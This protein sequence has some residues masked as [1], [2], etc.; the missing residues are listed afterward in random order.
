M[1]RKLIAS[2]LLGP[3]LMASAAGCADRK[4]EVELPKQE[5]PLPKDG[6]QA[7]GVATKGGKP[8]NPAAPAK[9]EQ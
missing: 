1:L 7:A 2:G 5:F 6:P 8:P 3:V 4:K 9:P